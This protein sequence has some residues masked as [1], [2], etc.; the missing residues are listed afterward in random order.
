V[1]NLPNTESAGEGLVRLPL[2]PSLSEA[3]FANVVSSAF[4]T[5]SEVTTLA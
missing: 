1:K 5:L 3:E 4:A 2:F